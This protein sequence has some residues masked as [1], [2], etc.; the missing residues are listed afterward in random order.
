MSDITISVNK[1][2]SLPLS[3]S[4]HYLIIGV[5]YTLQTVTLTFHDLYFEIIHSQ[6]QKNPPLSRPKRNGQTRLIFKQVLNLTSEEL[7]FILSRYYNV[8]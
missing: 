4:E 5:R 8:T 3:E 1:F 2:L 6:W 7:N